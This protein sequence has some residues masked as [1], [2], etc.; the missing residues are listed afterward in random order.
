MFAE[1]LWQNDVDFHQ[2]IS[3]LIFLCV[4]GHSKSMK[5][6]FFTVWRSL[7]NIDCDFIFQRFDLSFSPE[8]SSIEF[9]GEVTVKV[10]SIP[11]KFQMRCNFDVE[12]QVAVWT[13]ACP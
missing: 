9:N 12:I 3:K 13:A 7:G 6:E 5:S 11:L 1:V 8:K 2:H 4:D 10:I